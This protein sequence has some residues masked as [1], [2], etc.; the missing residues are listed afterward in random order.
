VL[1]LLSSS[2]THIHTLTQLNTSL[3]A[4]SYLPGSSLTTPVSNLDGW[5]WK[6][7]VQEFSLAKLDIPRICMA[8]AETNQ[9]LS[10]KIV[11][12]ETLEAALSSY[13]SY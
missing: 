4:C 8:L 1:S 3:I 2:S 13:V 11:F 7:D 10:E 6:Y 9:F 5:A 12:K